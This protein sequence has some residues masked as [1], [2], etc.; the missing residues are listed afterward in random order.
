MGGCGVYR[1][2]ERSMTT[3]KDGALLARGLCSVLIRS[4]RAYVRPVSAL[5]H[6]RWPRSFPR[7][8]FQTISRPIEGHGGMRSVPCRGS[9]D[10]TICSLSCKFW[11]RLSTV[12]VQ[13]LPVSGQSLDRACRAGGTD[14]VCVLLLCHPQLP[15]VA[16]QCRSQM[17]E[18]MA[19]PV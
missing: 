1:V 10:H 8:E 9:I 4:L 11:H 18:R 15:S 16:F 7:H 2:V 19:S 6:E 14:F 17:V 12:A 3:Y 5:A 13:L